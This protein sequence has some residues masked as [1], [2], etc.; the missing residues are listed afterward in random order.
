MSNNSD[1]QLDSQQPRLEDN[2]I[3]KTG[4][5]L[6]SYRNQQQ[7]ASISQSG[8]QSEPFSPLVSAHPESSQ[9]PISRL[10]GPI[11]L[12]SMP[13]PPSHVPLSSPL[14]SSRLDLIATQGQLGSIPGF[15]STTVDL[16][17]HWSGKVAAVAGYKVQPPAPYMERYHAPNPQ[18]AITESPVS[19]PQRKRSW[20]RSRTLRIAMQMRQR[21]ARWQRAP[22]RIWFPLVMG[23]LSILL[24][25]SFAGT[26]YSYG[27]YEHQLPRV[28]ELANAHIPQT[29]RIY[30]RNGTLL[31]EAY[32]QNSRQG[33]RRMA[34]HYE[35]I[36]R[37]M[38][39]A[40]VAIEDKTFW[41]NAGIEPMAIVRAAARQYGGGS[42][43]TQQVIK[44]LSNN[45]EYALDRKLTEAA[46]AIGLTRQYSKSKILEM[47][48]NI[49]AFGGQ[50]YGVEVAVE[51]YFGLRPDCKTNQKCIPGI[52]R[53]DY[54]QVTHKIDPLLGLARAS[55]LAGMPNQPGY[56]D[57]TLGPDAKGRAIA[58]QKLV[59]QQMMLQH[60]AVAGL[61]LVTPELASKASLLMERTSFQSYTRTKH[62]P[63][64]VDWIIN[65]VST[66]LG[67]GNA[68]DGYEVFQK[69]GLNIR[70]TI[71]VN[72]QEYVERAIERHIYQPEYQKLRGY[73]ATLSTYNNL[74][75]AAVVVMDARTGEILAMNGSANY[76]SDDPRVGGQFNAAVNSRPPGSTFKPIEYATAFQMGWYPGIMV[77]DNR[78]YFPNGAHVGAS[79]P[80][81]DKEASDKHSTIYAPYD[82]GH[83][84][85]DQLLTL[86]SS[87]A[88]S[89]NVPAI[90]AMQFSGAHEVLNTARRLG[91]TTQANTGLAWALGSKDVSPLQMVNAY[92]TF[93]N[94]GVR[95]PPQGVLDIW[96]NSGQNLYHYNPTQPPGGRVFS[97]QV[98]YLM[99]S[100]LADESSRAAEFG[101]DHDLSFADMDPN[102][103]YSHTTCT[104]QVAA[105]T[106]TTDEFRDNWTIG[107]TPDVV[108]GVWVGNANNEQ[109]KDVIGI[110]GAGPI[111]H[112]I[113]ERVMG[114]CNENPLPTNAFVAADQIACGPDYHFR[115]SQNPQ[116]TFSVPPGLEMSPAETLIGLR[117]G[118]QPDLT[119]ED[120]SSYQ[121]AAGI[122][123]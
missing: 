103:A 85:T 31:F 67:N 119:I 14:R 30:D 40:L 89:Y 58:R 15:L 32:D 97:P 116:W 21:R 79:L 5:L 55:L 69:A 101:S 1:Q 105:K 16:V 117:G 82:Y 92:Q 50:T 90:K 80:L 68:A 115:F 28:N 60:M 24:L 57:P 107:Y 93:A 42:T 39:D 48:F 75:S 106:G 108:V 43:L 47:Y 122:L 41:S 12:P 53:L 113:M 11:S 123:P 76:N 52:S 36:P 19:Q 109:M 78:T 70:T 99:T 9:V 25:V 110:T 33:G 87:I 56:N 88:N 72:L 77:Q 121:S 20:R 23:L 34:V 73:Y 112:S 63:H 62:A 81:S 118:G 91:I 7:A 4:G 120:L 44:N 59:L 86:R 114:R 10:K 45:R 17:R 49:A 84:Y 100:V 54:N 2:S 38:Q 6:T 46:M 98:S 8:I 51:D 104:R 3:P 71:D 29:T 37:V 94:D 102:C 95:I 83:N 111:W 18:P 96:D 26:S 27:Y 74:H 64:F 22:R 35:D 66:A 13:L 61:G 65:Q